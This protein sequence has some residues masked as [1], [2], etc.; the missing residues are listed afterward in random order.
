M[1]DAAQAQVVA[2]AE[3]AQRSV[4]SSKLPLFY[5]DPTKDQFA[6]DQWME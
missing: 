3:E 4:E 6:P 2:A 1:G 5:K